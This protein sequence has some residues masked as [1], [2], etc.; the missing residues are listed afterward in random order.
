[1]ALTRGSDRAMKGACIA[2]LENDTHKSAWQV[3]VSSY[4]LVLSM[5][6]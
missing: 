4:H 3:T 6:P 2:A 5:P 1:M